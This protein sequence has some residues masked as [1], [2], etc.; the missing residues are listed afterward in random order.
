MSRRLASA[1]FAILW[2]IPADAQEDPYPH[3]RPTSPAAGSPTPPPTPPESAGDAERLAAAKEQFRR[4]VA[5][6]AAGDLQRALDFFIESRTRYPSAKNT[7]NAAVCLDRLGRL[8]EAVELYEEALG[9]FGA[10]LDAADRSSIGAALTALRGKLG[11]VDISANVEGSIVIDGRLRGRL[12]LSGPIR[13][14]AGRHAL[15]I[16]KGGYQTY[17]ASVE[18]AVGE[19]AKLDARLAP[20][21]QAGQLRVEDPGNDGADVF[22]DG[23]AVGTI[24]WEDTLSVG[25]H[26]LWTRKGDIGSAPMIAVVVEGQTAVLRVRSVTLGKLVR[27]EIV[28]TT[29]ELRIDSVP[30]GVGFWEGRLPVGPH[31]IA[32]NEAGYRAAT[33]EVTTTE[34]GEPFVWRA[35]LDVD[36]T[37]PRWP[38]P[39]SGSVWFEVLGG[40][41]IG[42]TF[43]SD[44]ESRCPEACSDD[45]P[46]KGF[47]LGARGGYRFTMGLG[48][49]L[50]AGY[51]HLEKGLSR[52]AEARFPTDTQAYA[53]RY[54]LEDNIRVRGPFI[55]PALSYRLDVGGSVGVIGRVAAGL[56]F[57]S[58]RDGVDGTA[59]TGAESVDVSVDGAEDSVSSTAFFVH[60]ELGLDAELGE[61]RVGAAVGVAVFL[62]E[63][64]R[65]EHSSI[66]VAPSC[67]DAAPS[68][69][70]CAPGSRALSGEK[71]FDPFAVFTPQIFAGYEF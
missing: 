46:V 35:K 13:L 23:A 14:G 57:A 44:A 24:P 42:S 8:D 27:L 70:G 64:P 29:A 2:A 11:A 59:T 20:L 56:V 33:V 41:A 31:Q 28:P 6:F 52:H 15:R 7:L 54:D 49:E 1:L 17:E 63:G 62:T 26:V 32:A 65:F 37:H 48:L 51:L 36:P 18:I 19:T 30:V 25:R 4:G 43:S 21:V 22:V 67:D 68:A 69:V 61:F 16:M 55:A 10:D 58:S 38:R 5:L 12:P 60:P 45:P 34:D 3:D 53:V 40:G 47:L 71:A 66:D 39:P 9:R 50:S